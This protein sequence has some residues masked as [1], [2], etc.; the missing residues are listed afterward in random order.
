MKA[1]IER[2]GSVVLELSPEFT[3]EGDPETYNFN[4]FVVGASA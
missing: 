3:F 4:A 2:G 1:T